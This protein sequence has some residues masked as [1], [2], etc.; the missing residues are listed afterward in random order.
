MSPG[1][2]EQMASLL[3][4]AGI[5]SWVLKW[6]MDLLGGER[7]EAGNLWPLGLSSPLSVSLL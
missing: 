7:S 1:H 6:G 2:R 5:T 4:T 3:P